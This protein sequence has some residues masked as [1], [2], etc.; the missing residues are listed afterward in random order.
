MSEEITTERIHTELPI[1]EDEDIDVD[2][3]EAGFLESVVFRQGGKR[4]TGLQRNKALEI[5]E[6]YE[7]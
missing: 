5:L 1:N 6:K 7:R 4:M 3:W 2:S